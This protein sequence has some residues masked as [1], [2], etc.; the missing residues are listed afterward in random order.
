MNIEKSL[1]SKEEYKIKATFVSLEI[2]KSDVSVEFEGESILHF[3]QWGD[4]EWRLHITDKQKS[5]IDFLFDELVL[6]REEKP[7]GGMEE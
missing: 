5:N 3:I 4:H 7:D 1:Q 2:P 6:L